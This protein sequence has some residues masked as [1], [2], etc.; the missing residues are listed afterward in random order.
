MLSRLMSMN[1]IGLVL[2]LLGVA[3]MLLGRV[4]PEKWKLPGKLVSLL[5]AFIGAALC[6]L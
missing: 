4:L 1:P 3:V 2:L 6:F 5:L